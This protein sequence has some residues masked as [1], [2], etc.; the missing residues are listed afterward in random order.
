MPQLLGLTGSAPRHQAPSP[1]N[2][3]ECPTGSLSPALN[4]KPFEHLDLIGSRA[5][6]CWVAI[7][8]IWAEI[9]CGRIEQLWRQQHVRSNR[10]HRNVDQG[11]NR[12]TKIDNSGLGA[13]LLG[14]SHSLTLCV[15]VASRSPIPARPP[16]SRSS[17]S[18]LLP[19]F[20]GHVH[21]ACPGLEAIG[22]QAQGTC[23]RR[24]CL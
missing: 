21:P 10:T 7:R 2:V 14:L 4:V 13:A 12:S 11:S 18:P 17:N 9:C 6:L 16:A 15:A 5:S 19:P 3:T 22:P 23:I 20:R 24:S 8:P 1:P